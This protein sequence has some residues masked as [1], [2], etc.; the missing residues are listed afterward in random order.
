MNAGAKER[1]RYSSYLFLTLALDGGWVVSVTPRPRFY[2]RVKDP[3]VQ[4]L[5][6]KSF[7]LCQGSNLDHPVVQ[8]V[9]RH[10]TDWA[11]TVPIRIVDALLPCK[12]G[13]KKSFYHV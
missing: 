7:R 10:Y 12:Y 5:E 6:E 2:P 8:S 9:F 1:R 11:T 13:Y 3:P 4:R